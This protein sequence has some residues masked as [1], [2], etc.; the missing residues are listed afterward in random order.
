MSRR[1]ALKSVENALPAPVASTKTQQLAL[2]A[3]LEAEAALEVEREQRQSCEAE[4]KDLAR[5][6]HIANTT[7]LN[8]RHA[9]ERESARYEEEVEAMCARISALERINEALLREQKNNSSRS[10]LPNWLMCRGDNEGERA[11]P[12]GCMETSCI[13]KRCAP[14]ALKAPACL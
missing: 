12:S 14:P 8:S 4:K 2:V 10:W 9:A 13:G 1:A 3:K 7:L 5:A 11:P 6:L